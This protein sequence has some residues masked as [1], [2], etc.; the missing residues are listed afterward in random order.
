MRPDIATISA[1]AELAALFSLVPQTLQVPSVDAINAQLL[2]KLSAIDDAR[3]LA[4]Q[5]TF[6]LVVAGESLPTIWLDPLEG[7]SIRT[8]ARHALYA[9]LVVLGQQEQDD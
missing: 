6:E 2:E 1:G 3:R 7:L 8:F 5:T 9:D 4:T